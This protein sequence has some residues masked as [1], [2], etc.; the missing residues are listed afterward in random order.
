[1]EIFDAS[2]SNG[3]ISEEDQH[4]II[5]LTT[6]LD[7]RC[8]ERDA[9]EFADL[10][11]ADTDFRF[12]TG[13]WVKGKA[14]IESFWKNKVFPGLPKSLKHLSI[15]K[16]VR[17]VSQDFII[18]DGTLRFVDDSS[19]KEQIHSEREATLIAVKKEGCWR[20]SAVRLV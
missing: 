7:K 15:I 11:E 4:S 9:K 2:V 16:R 17:F 13:P 20:I 3:S 18:G 10:F 1:M 14:A 6:E 12:Y 8:N 19:G 5:E